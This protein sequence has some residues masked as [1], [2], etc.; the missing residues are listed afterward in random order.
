MRKGKEKAERGNGERRRG[1]GK[2]KEKEKGER[3]RDSE[4]RKEN[5]SKEKESNRYVPKIAM[6]FGVAP[7][8]KIVILRPGCAIYRRYLFIVFAPS[9]FRVV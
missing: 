8:P 7:L 6:L 4:R 3:E 1:R 5:E 9:T 2:G